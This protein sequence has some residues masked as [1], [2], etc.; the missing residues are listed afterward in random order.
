MMVVVEFEY[1]SQ[2]FQDWLSQRWVMAR[3]RRVEPREID[4]LMGP[5]GNVDVIGDQYIARLASDESLEIER[6]D[7]GVGLM[8][9]IDQFGL[10]SSCRARLAPQIADFYL[11][12]AD[13]DLEV[14]SEW[15]ALFRPFGG[16]LQRVYSRRLQQLN[17]PLR[18]LD[19]ARGLRSQIIKL[20]RPDDGEARY[21][22]WHRGLKSTGQTSYSGVYST[23][24]IPDGRMCMKAVFPLPRGNATVV[25]SIRVGERG[26]LELLSSG[27]RFGDP[28]FYFL[29]HDSRGRHWAQYIRSFRERLTLFVDQEQTLRADHALTLWG[30]RVLQLHYKITPALQRDQSMY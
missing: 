7:R 12:T 26:E 27:E 13:H 16:L 20:R 22:I 5:F 3:G 8:N 21:T 23:C 28:G 29:L 18:P 2:R 1:P 19:T 17:L 25:M 9:S 6:H 4:W 24:R 14:W 15:N 11:R 30:R 10:D